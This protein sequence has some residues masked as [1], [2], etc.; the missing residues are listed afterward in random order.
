MQLT[1]GIYLDGACWS[2]KTASL[3]ELRLGPFGMLNL[4]ETR[5]GLTGLSVHPAARINQ[6]MQRLQACDGDGKWFHASFGADPWSTAK[7]MLAWRDQLIEAGWCGQSDKSDSARLQALAELEQTEMSL[8]NGREDRLQQV[9]RQLKQTNSIAISHI[10]LHEPLELLPPVWKKV[11]GQLQSMGVNVEPAIAPPFVTAPANLSIIQAQLSGGSKVSE[12]SQN[13]D[14][15]LLIKAADEWQAAEN[16]ALWLAADTAGNQDVTVVC[17]ANTDVLDQALQ[18]H[19][20]PQFGDSRSSR[21]RASLQVLPLVFANAW[22][23][24]DIYRLV[25]LLSLPLVPV[26]G[27]AARRFLRAISQEPGVGGIAWNKALQDIA[28]RYQEKKKKKGK[29]ATD[30]EAAAFAAD[31]DNFL[32]LDRYNAEAGIPESVIK[33]R[34]QRVIERLA[35]RVDSD[36]MLGEVISH[37]REMQKLAEGKGNIPRVSVERMLDSVIGIGSSAPDRIEQA[38]AWQV[39]N[40]PGATTHP[41]KTII[42]WGFTD[43]E[44][45][46]ATY[47]S[48][49]ERDSLRQSGA[50]LEETRIIRSR[51]AHAWRQG[52]GYAEEHML[53]FYPTRQY[54][55][56]AYHH[57]FWDEIR[58]AAARTKPGQQEDDIISCLTRECT[59]LHDKG[60]W[61]L[62]GRTAQLQKV[63]KSE[64]TAIT[65]THI[66]PKEAINPPESLSYSQMS[67]MIGCP[68]NW[69]LK[70]HVGLRALDAQSVAT[71]NLMIGNLCHR[72]VQEL[73]REPGKHW[74]PEDAQGRA[75][76]LYDSL[77][78]SMAAELLVNGR[79]LDNTRYREAI[80]GAVRQLVE[81]IVLQGLIVEKSEEILEGGLLGE[82]PF[83]G[84]A[85]LLLRDK[86]GNIFVLDLKWSG[87][88]K[89]KKEEVE[90][91]NALQL[92]T[93]A[94]ILGSLD[95]ALQVHTGYFM[96]AQ[97]ELLSDSSLLSKEPLDSP[98]SLTE[99]WEVGSQSWNQ[100][101]EE[102]R[103]G[104]MEAR[105]VYERLYMAEKGLN[106]EQLQKEMKNKD[107]SQGLLYQR[108]SCGYCDFTSLC[109]A[110]GEL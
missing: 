33:Q 4:L 54:G 63:E 71:G 72:I 83:G 17:G 27:F 10:Y 95:P 55:E 39:V 9:L 45:S 79:E 22:E 59:Q 52:L 93:Y 91:G 99:T 15:L 73:Y 62:A 2:D 7:Q 43:P 88:S 35:W 61:Q 108:P 94:W 82:I 20:L 89:Y 70:Y 69:A 3:G 100:R 36:P 29:V 26:P 53:L 47:W 41:C 78:A 109:G 8:A 5:L 18:R 65:A 57:P 11:I 92:A 105:G 86:R 19:G 60:L 40:H 68:M 58:S 101:F 87:T 28:A 12:I 96:L 75:L 84:R 31:L 51:E 37:A 50:E 32:T 38:A 6:Y 81:A 102:L 74:S 106:K 66:I 49:S 21:W 23:P 77:I 16:L 76:E 30:E 110:G 44:T 14:S 97:G 104:R 25:E 107:F 1:F 103:S 13:D 56:V 34:C 90:E 80:A 24:L 98:R 64:Q 48:E 67:S 46:P 42:W 85:D